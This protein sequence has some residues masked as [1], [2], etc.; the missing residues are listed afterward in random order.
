MLKSRGLCLYAIRN[1]NIFF[2][3][4]TDPTTHSET[5]A[6]HMNEHRRSGGT[7]DILY[8]E[9]RTSQLS[10]NSHQARDIR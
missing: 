2:S 4:R 7:N 5:T 9:S 10:K 6:R 8:E 3:Y 1:V